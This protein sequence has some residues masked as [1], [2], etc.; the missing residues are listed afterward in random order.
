[1][2]SVSQSPTDMQKHRQC[3]AAKSMAVAY[4]PPNSPNLAPCYF[5]CFWEGNQSY[6]GVVSRKSL[7]YGNSR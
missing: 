2:M 7:K 4:H 1:M 3:S 6:K 5:F